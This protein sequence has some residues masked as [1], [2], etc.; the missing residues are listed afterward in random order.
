MDN[1]L[2]LA[3]YVP[4]N[5]IGNSYLRIKTVTLPTEAE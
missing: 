5:H 4:R 1:K 2:F 3:E